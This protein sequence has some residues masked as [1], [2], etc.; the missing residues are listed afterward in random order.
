MVRRLAVLLACIC[1]TQGGEARAAVRALIV[2]VAAYDSPRVSPLEGP[3]N[4]A[5]AMAALMLG[6]GATDIITLLDHAATRESIRAALAELATR[7]EPGDWIVFFYAGHG[8]QAVARDQQEADGLDEFLVL[9]GFHPEAPEPSQF[10]LD[11][12]LHRWLQELFPADVNILQI[13]DACHSGTLNRSFSSAAGFRARKA[14][15]N[16]MVSRLPVVSSDPIVSRALVGPGANVVFIG[17]SQDDQLALEGP[18]PR[19]DSPTRGVLTYALESALRDRRDD[20]R[21]AADLDLDGRLSLAELTAALTTRTRQISGTRQWSRAVIPKGNER[22]EIFLP[23]MPDADED[24][25]VRIKAADGEA[26]EVL[27]GRGPWASVDEG[28]PDLIWFAREGTLTD[29]KGDR[30]ADN[31]TSTEGILGAI[32]NRGALKRLYR[33]ADERQLKVEIGPHRPGELYHRDDV[34]EI[35]VKL[36]AASGFLTAFNLTGDGV[37][38]LIYPL[39]DEGPGR[40]GNGERQ[41]LIAAFAGP[42]FGAD[43]IVVVVTGEEPVSL[44]TALQR[45]NGRRESAAAASLVISEVERDAGVLA[46]GEV[47]TGP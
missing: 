45:M 8:A 24:P 7:V 26:A 11:N 35:K 19:A 9:S 14:L 20:G 2:G 39:E 25:P 29:A 43:H 13:A 15:T 16:P 18:L 46:L 28:Q 23:L 27:G 47:F 37:V 41:T 38:Q 34:L 44:R 22:S 6:Q 30:I 10:V 32:A 42:P 40:V 36:G 1:L 33:A 21:L 3:R 31:L 17:A 12:D 5:A 4:D